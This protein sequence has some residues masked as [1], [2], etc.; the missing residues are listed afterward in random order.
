M[1]EITH[2]PLMG[3]YILYDAGGASVKELADIERAAF[4]LLP[5]N[6]CVHRSDAGDHGYRP[7]MQQEAWSQ[8]IMGQ[9]V[10][11][12]RESVPIEKQAGD[13]VIGGTVNADKDDPLTLYMLPLRLQERRFLFTGT[14]YDAQKLSITG[15]PLK[16]ARRIAGTTRVPSTGRVKSGA[17]CPSSGLLTL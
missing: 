1:C 14:H 8:H 2:T 15:F 10:S 5:E 13:E 12:A 17:G 4:S 6:Q 3:V 9:P 11:E 16:L 7:T